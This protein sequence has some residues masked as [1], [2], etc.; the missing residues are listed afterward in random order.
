MPRSRG[1]ELPQRQSPRVP[2]HLKTSAL[3]DPNGVN[4]R[5]PRPDDRRSPRSPLHEKKRGGTKVADLE[6]KLGKA[7]EELKKLRDQLVSA[8]SAKKDAQVALDEAKKRISTVKPVAAAVEVEELEECIT[9]E[10]D[11]PKPGEE[12]VNSPATDVFEV[13]VPV[14]SESRESETNGSVNCVKGEEEI[15]AKEEEETKKMVDETEEEKDSREV[16]D[17][18]A[19]ISDM[20]MEMGTL[21]AENAE[22]K[23]KSEEA[24]AAARAKQEEIEGELRS[25]RENSLR[26]GQELEAAEGE[27]EAMQAELRRLRVQ[28]EQWRKA[29]EAAAAALGDGVGIGARR[30]AGRCGSMDKHLVGYGWM[31][32]EEEE[33]M[34][35]GGKRRSPGIRMLGDLWKKKGQHK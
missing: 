3:S 30:V 15:E 26:L 10:S 21:K 12:S 34:V 20:E 29:A 18:K 11:K 2:L 22:L 4:H 31:G 1:S 8:E 19:K 32:E 16:F 6:T 25:S 33:E 35:G 28:T 7:Q 24:A 27:K 9:Q 5:S 17:L 13:V 23:K 14:E